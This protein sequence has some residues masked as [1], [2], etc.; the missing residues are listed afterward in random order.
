MYSLVRMASA[1]IVHVA[2][3][4]A[5]ETNGPPSQTNTFFA[6]CAWHHSF[7]T[8]ALGSFPMRVEPHSWMMRPPGSR[9]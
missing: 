6:S 8:D 2:F 9:P 1:R 5:C 7:S 3:L 4:S